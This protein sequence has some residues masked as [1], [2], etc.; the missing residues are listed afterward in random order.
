M[1]RALTPGDWLPEWP[2]EGFQGAAAGMTRP[3]VERAMA[4]E[5]SIVEQAVARA[6]RDNLERIQRTTE[7]L[8]ML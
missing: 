4:Q 2:D 5:P 8:P 6:L 3:N 1:R 7:E